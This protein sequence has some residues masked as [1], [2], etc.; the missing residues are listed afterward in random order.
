MKDAIEINVGGIKCDNPK[1]DY[2]NDKIELEDYEKWVNKPCPKCGENLFTKIDLENTMRL[3]NITK[4]IN[5]IL[6]KSE[7]NEETSTMTVE[8]NSTGEMKFS[9]KE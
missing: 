1:C 8:M 3:V 9:I 6:P 4:M 7:D 2:R 5:N